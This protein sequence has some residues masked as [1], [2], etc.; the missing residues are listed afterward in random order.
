M[1]LRRRVAAAA[2]AATEIEGTPI[3]ELWNARCTVAYWD[4]VSSDPDQRELVIHFDNGLV[5]RAEPTF[6]IER[7]EPDGQV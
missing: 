1:S 5:V 7:T 3:P 6:T 4:H 2:L